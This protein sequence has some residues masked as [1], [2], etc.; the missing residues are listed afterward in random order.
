MEVF[1]EVG[2]G[3]GGMEWLGMTSTVYFAKLSGQQTGATAVAP[4]QRAS[5]SGR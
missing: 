2:G 1:L 3:W 4:D 5:C